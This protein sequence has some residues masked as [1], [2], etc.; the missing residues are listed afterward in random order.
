LDF[1]GA[2]NARLR[3]YATRDGARVRA[4]LLYRSGMLAELTPAGQQQLQ[5]SASA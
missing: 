3:G 1:P 2:V 4:G 5:H